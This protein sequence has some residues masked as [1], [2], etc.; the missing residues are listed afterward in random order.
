[1]LNNR[2]V[3]H[4]I[5]SEALRDGDHKVT[6]F[7]F[8]LMAH[9]SKGNPL[10]SDIS[11]ADSGSNY[12]GDLV[13]RKFFFSLMPMINFAVFYDD[14]KTVSGMSDDE[15]LNAYLRS[16]HVSAASYIIGRDIMI[17]TTGAI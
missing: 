2:R 16:L 17:D 13:F 3:L 12:G 15:M 1:M 11:L 8:F 14:Y 5:L 7:R 9:S 4:I 10:F 6:L